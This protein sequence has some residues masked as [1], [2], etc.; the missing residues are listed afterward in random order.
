MKHQ[1]PKDAV[2]A[3]FRSSSPEMRESL[4]PIKT[5]RYLVYQMAE[6]AYHA[7]FLAEE[8]RPTRFQIGLL[9]RDRVFA[10]P[11]RVLDEMTADL[12]RE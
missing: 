5:P 11:G 8:G 9:Q 12:S 7:S 4:F 1:Y 10:G 3:L 2:D 6:I